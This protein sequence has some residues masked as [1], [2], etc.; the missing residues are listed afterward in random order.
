MQESLENFR[1]I[2]T[3]TP[4]Q[5]LVQDKDL[6]YVQVIN[7]QWGL[8]E[9]DMIGNTDYDLFSKEDADT[10][11]QQKRHVL[12]H[13]TAVQSEMSLINPSGE[14]N[15]FVISYVPK[16]NDAGEIEGLIG[17]FRNVTEI[18][19]ANEKTLAALAE[20]EI[21]IREIHH[22]VKNNLQII[23]GLLD[24]T[25][26]RAHDPE[27]TSILTDMMLKIK[28]MAQIHTRLYESKQFDKINMGG[29]IH[30]M[31]ADLSSI[32]GKSGAGI[33]CQVNA[34]DLS[35]PVDQAIPCALTVNEVLSNSFKHAFTGR[36]EGTIAITARID[37]NNV[38]ISVQDD[39]IGIPENVDVDRATSLGL[40]LIRSLV[41]QLRGTLTIESSDRGSNVTINF[42]LEEGGMK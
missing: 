40:K 12:E 14:R 6:R 2:A 25:R 36:N 16:K 38:H 26:M 35:L 28:T 24:M 1:I 31:V 7:P 21:L 13:G 4:D 11:T 34:E 27:T 29:Q 30:D 22:R 33:T 41:Q 39:G 8:T 19:Q 32:Y 23:S 5:I 3:H 15:H 42:P 18:K 20:K 37:G 9:Q 10:I 17:Y